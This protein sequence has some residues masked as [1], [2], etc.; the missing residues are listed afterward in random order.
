ML[1]PVLL[2]YLYM[3]I[4]MNN[5]NKNTAL[6]YESALDLKLPLVKLEQQIAGFEVILGRKR[7][8]FRGGE[9]PFNYGSNVSIASNK[10][11][12]NKMLEHAGFPVP[13]AKAFNREQFKKE[14]IESLINNLSFPLVVKP[15]TG[16]AGGEDVL[17]NISDIELLNAY[18]KKCYKRHKSLLVEEFHGGLTT[19][20][21]LVFYHKVIGVVERSP[22]KVIGDGIHSI[23]ELITMYNDDREKAKDDVVSLSD[24]GTIKITEELDIRLKEM[25]L[26]LASIPRSKE[27]ILLGYTCDTSRGGTEISLGKKICKE[28]ARMLCRA[29]DVLGLNIVGFDLVCEDILVPISQSRGVII[30]ANH[31][32]A[33]EMHEQPISGIETPIT[34]KILRRLIFRHP[35]A[36]FRALSKQE[37]IAFYVR[38]FFFLSCLAVCWQGY[39]AISA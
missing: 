30:E 22:A 5:M 3:F 39:L 11:C 27:T 37:S 18:M 20:R 31:N 12:M 36:Y 19:Y 21:V 28:N 23:G 24:H 17:C 10:F 35:F 26:T 38:I 29:A 2:L 25:Q 14:K 4:R 6:Y 32:P 16:S 15:M 8:F 1:P 13:K 9:T 34:K 33:V 7:Y